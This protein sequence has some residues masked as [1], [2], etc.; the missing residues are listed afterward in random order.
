MKETPDRKTAA[1]VAD[2][3]DRMAVKLADVGLVAPRD[4]KP[5]T[6]LGTFLDDYLLKRVDVKPATKEVWGQVVRNLKDH[7]G[8]NRDMATIN[9]GHAEDFKLYL[10]SEKLSATTVYKRL[11]FARMF[12]RAARK[13]KLI[14]DNPFAE[15][16][17]KAVVKKEKQYYVTHEATAKLLEAAN[18]TG[19]KSSHG[20]GTAAYA[21]LV[22]F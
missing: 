14:T 9:E 20:P 19:A 6:M 8:E 17:A 1:W 4:A 21:V 22:R 3:D 15:V 18:P 10:V 11:Q 5:E 2:L 12:F 7:L 13:R 16:R